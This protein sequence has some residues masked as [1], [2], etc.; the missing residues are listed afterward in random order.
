MSEETAKPSRRPPT[1]KPFE[2]LTI[3]DNYMFQ[4][5]MKNEKLIK[6]LLEMILGKK[7]RKIVVLETEK[8][9]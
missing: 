3:T 2:K 6:P 7:I 1:K 8:T 9:Q 5:V 4:A